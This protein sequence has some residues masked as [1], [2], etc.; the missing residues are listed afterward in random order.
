MA[1]RNQ[2][3]RTNIPLGGT[4]ELS[5]KKLSLTSKMKLTGSMSI[6]GS[7][8][9]TGSVDITGSTGITGSLTVSDSIKLKSDNPGAAVEWLIKE[10]VVVISGTGTRAGLGHTTGS[11][12]PASS[13]VQAV[14]LYCTGAAPTGKL[15][16][17]GFKDGNPVT[18]HRALVAGEN[19]NDRAKNYFFTG[20]SVAGGDSLGADFVKNVAFFTHPSGGVSNFFTGSCEIDVGLEPSTT[21]GSIALILYYTQFHGPTSFPG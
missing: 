6:T 15:Q 18:M 8:V 5:V 16:Y 20:S 7:F 2:F 10:Q 17:V 1:K 21:T 11:F 9:H 12:I 19:A 14:A 13:S 4:G 3:N